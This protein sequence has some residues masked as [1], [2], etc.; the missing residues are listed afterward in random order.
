MRVED[1]VTSVGVK[2]RIL[3]T[4]KIGNQGETYYLIRLKDKLLLQRFMII[5]EDHYKGKKYALSID[6]YYSSMAMGMKHIEYCVSLGS[7]NTLK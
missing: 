3:Y 7:R 6:S 2:G 4:Q 1:F 5:H